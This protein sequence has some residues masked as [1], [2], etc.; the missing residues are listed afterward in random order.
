MARPGVTKTQ[1]YVSAQIKRIRG[2]RKLTHEKAAKLAGVSRVQ[3]NRYEN[4]GTPMPSDVLFNFAKGTK[5]QVND[6]FPPIE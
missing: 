4:R 5:T 3:W 6:F 2:D 1:K